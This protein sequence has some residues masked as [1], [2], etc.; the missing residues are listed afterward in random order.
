MKTYKN[1]WYFEFS[2][3]NLLETHQIGQDRW[4]LV[5]IR[6]DLA[7]SSWDSV[8]SHRDL[9][10]SRRI[11]P[12][13]RH[14]QWNPKPTGTSRS[15][16]RPKPADPTN[17]PSWLRVPFSP[18]RQVQVESESGT[19]S[20]WPDLWTLLLLRNPNHATIISC[21]S[22]HE[23]IRI[24]FS[25]KQPLNSINSNLELHHPWVFGSLTHH[26]LMGLLVNSVETLGLN[27]VIISGIVLMDLAKFG[28]DLIK[29]S[30]YGWYTWRTAKINNLVGFFRKRSIID[31]VLSGSTESRIGPNQITLFFFFLFF[32]RYRTKLDNSNLMYWIYA[33]FL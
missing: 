29:F 1:R 32:F 5:Q 31:R 10:K 11:R 25:V 17:I 19:N 16:T 28:W 15:P 4:D 33:F 9:A 6:W 30:I 18:T 26:V 24:R 23:P 3:K 12:E 21:K 27:R 2:D 13:R 7:R 8:R 20:T 14:R 22:V